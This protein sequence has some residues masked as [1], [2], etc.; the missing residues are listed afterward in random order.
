[1]VGE[2]IDTAGQGKAKKMVKI[3]DMMI[4]EGKM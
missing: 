3:C 1:M 2:I 4:D